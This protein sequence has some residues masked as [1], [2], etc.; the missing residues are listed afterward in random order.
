MKKE[1]LRWT[2][3][4]LNQ[5]IKMK[6]LSGLSLFQALLYRIRISKTLFLMEISQGFETLIPK[7][8]SQD[9]FPKTFQYYDFILA[10]VQ[11]GVP[12]LVRQKF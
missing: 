9:G 8:L 6:A 4:T 10:M 2:Y 12:L 5:V 11:E 7:D 3:N 1:D